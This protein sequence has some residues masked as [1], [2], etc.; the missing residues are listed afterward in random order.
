MKDVRQSLSQR[1]DLNEP[2]FDFVWNNWATKKGLIFVWRA[3]EERI[4]TATALR[5][6]GMNLS[7]T[8][9]KTC[10]A[11]EESAAHVLL[12]CNLAKRV[13]EKITMWIRIPMVNTDGNLKELL[14]ELNEMNCSRKMRKVIQQLLS[15]QCGLFGKSGMRRSSAIDKARYK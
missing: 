9:C 3:I 6:R 4:P 5:H 13:W 8:I 11:A 12:Q 2:A 15:K 14:S 10:G 1:M 7:E